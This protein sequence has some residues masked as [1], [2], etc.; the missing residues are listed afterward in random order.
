[1]GPA[2]RSL[3]DL[4]AAGILKIAEKPPDNY[5]DPED[6]PAYTVP[7]IAGD[8]PALTAVMWNACYRAFG[9]TARNIM[10]VADPKRAEEIFAALRA[11]PKYHGGGCGLG[12]KE[13]AVPLL[14]E[15]TNAAEA[16]GAVNIVKKLPDGRLIGD[17]TDGLGFAVALEERF[18]TRGESVASKRVLVIGARGSGRAIAVALA[19]RGATLDIVNRTA[20]LATGLAKRV[21][22]HRRA[23]VAADGGLDAIPRLLPTADA[24]V[25]AVDDPEHAL[26]VYSPLAPMPMPA[27]E[28]AVK[29]N[30]E[31]SRQLLEQAKPGLVIS[32]IRI[33]THRLPLI[34]Q[35]AELG[36]E[37]FTGVP[38]VVNQAIEAFWWLY[39][40]KLG[41]QGRKK[42]EVAAIMQEAATQV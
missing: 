26:D 27:T 23:F 9:M 20:E 12:F 3:A 5:R 10:V 29:Q 30:L 16:I 18:G 14:D 25:A 35:A 32:D 17:N 1:M 34:R 4:F 15:L 39:G 31:Q 21:N 6:A 24:V 33:R 37:A 13:V 41:A 42:E 2:P 19:E 7:L 38:M 8:Y 36:Y 22:E 11:D 40:D 28:E